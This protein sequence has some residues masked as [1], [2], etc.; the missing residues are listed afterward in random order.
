MF[1]TLSQKEN[2]I[3]AVFNLSSANALKLVKAKKL[4]FG[5]ELTTVAQ[6]MLERKGDYPGSLTYTTFTQ[7]LGLKC[8]PKDN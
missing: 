6:K 1:S 2:T 8:H 7:D 4:P 5:K 3:L